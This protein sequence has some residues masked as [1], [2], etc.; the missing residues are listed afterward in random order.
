MI[1]RLSRFGILVISIML[2]TT[3]Y[4]GTG[5]ELDSIAESYVKL[6]LE[7]G[8]YDPDLID[9]YI[10]PEEWKPSEKSHADS[11]A[12]FEAFHADANS[13][14]DRLHEIEASDLK[15]LHLKRYTFL[16][17]QI[18]ALVGRLEMLTGKRLSF[19]EETRVLYDLEL[20]SF[21]KAYYDSLLQELDKR[22]PG[23]GSVADRFNA[24]QAQFRVPGAKVYQIF[25][26]GT[27]E[28]RNRISRYVEL[29]EDDSVS[30][31]IVRERWWTANCRYK[32]NRHSHMQLN[33]DNPFFLDEA[34]T[35]PCHELY[36][37][38]HLSFLMI[39]Q[40]LLEDSG[41]VEFSILPIFSPF[42]AM[43]EGTAEYGIDLTFPK[44]AWVEFVK[45]TLCPIIEAD[46]SLV[47][48]YY[49]LWHLKYQLYAVES[50]IARQY[51]DGEIDGEKAKE[52]L[53][54][55]AIYD[56]DEVGS[57]IDAYDSYG[58]YVVNYYVGKDL[59]RDYVESSAGG[60]SD[61]AALWTTFIELLKTPATPS[62]L[63]ATR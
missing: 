17:K 62:G 50:H 14:F 49:D 18:N 19:E 25:K 58:S 2:A 11:V 22:L 23:N 20:P 31:E 54:Y 27:T 3:L 16:E 33:I 63:R 48:A 6:V 38:H 40:H 60:E 56:Q 52:L 4:A 9:F 44:E 47:D 34:I 53:Q 32:G 21:N 1:S 45:T 59:V 26:V 24:F 46:T 15:G 10:G 5:T 39:G 12:P 30:I 29:P 41:W 13:L 51:L 55:Y 7:V 37:G 61:Q 35:F 36:P 8:Q 43:L 42:A 57:R 28:A